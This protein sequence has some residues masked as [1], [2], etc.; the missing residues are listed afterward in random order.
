MSSNRSVGSYLDIHGFKAIISTF[1]KSKGCYPV[2]KLVIQP[3]NILYEW[4]IFFYINRQQSIVQFI[5]YLH[6]F[7][8]MKNNE[9]WELD[10]RK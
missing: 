3:D 4:H 5:I 7:L 10:D 8:F 1:V 2:K 6:R 9:S